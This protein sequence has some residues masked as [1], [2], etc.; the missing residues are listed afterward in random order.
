MGS[1]GTKRL[2][3]PRKAPTQRRSRELV[4][5]I[6]KATTRVLVKE[7]YE[8]CNT[9]RIAEVAGVSVGSVY[10]YF[11]NKEALVTRVMERHQER[12]Q[13]VVIGHLAELEDASLDEAAK[14]LV[15]AMID[16]HRV[17]PKLHQ[18][19]VEQVPRIGALKRL[20]E[21]R[22]AYEPLIAS[23]L[24]AH[25]ERLRLDE[26]DP[27]ETAWLLVGAVDGVLNR[28]L[29]QRPQSLEDGSLERILTRLITHY[30]R[31]G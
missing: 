10:Q 25:R 13:A 11:P 15:R 26:L 2:V 27:A 7:G 22:D 18:V 3:S 8:G 30:L 24:E 1:M 5:T 16:A 4:D 14:T 9:N 19:L 17:E 20:R 31:T 21:F 6:L 29:S 28:V 23:W 12:V